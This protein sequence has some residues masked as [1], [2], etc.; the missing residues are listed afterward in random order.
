ML[1]EAPLVSIIIPTY[2]QSD[3]LGKAIGSALNQSYS[4][5][6]II[7]CDDCSSDN[8]EQIVSEFL[9]DKR[10]KYF[11][12]EKNLGRVTNYK[13]G[14]YNR[15]NGEW[16]VNL[17]GDD[18]F[19]Y[20]TYIEEAIGLVAINENVVFVQAGEI[21]KNKK[22]EIE[23]LPKIKEE[24]LFLSGRDYFLNFNID[25]HFSHMATM[26]KRDVA[27][28]VGFYQNDIL[29]SDIE[30]ILKL[31][32]FG[33]VI[34]FKKCIGVWYIHENN[35]SSTSKLND[36]LNNLSFID[37]CFLESVEHF[38]NKIRLKWKNSMYNY[39]FTN[40]VL[41][42]LSNKSHIQNIKSLCVLFFKRPYLFSKKYVLVSIYRY[43]MK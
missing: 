12:N 30:S 39:F 33:N 13:N 7:V 41:N 16:V 26:Y 11:K 3:L 37:T 6:E 36:Y 31:A 38:D 32:L 21:M 10:V 28:E 17:D 20:N 24:F 9:N 18:F 27:I 25:Y 2:N 4:N 14:L 8:T 22:A 1:I 23:K 15:A 29:S 34:L 5:I 42:E 40:I 19:I 35:A 43:F